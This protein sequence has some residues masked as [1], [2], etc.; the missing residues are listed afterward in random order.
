MLLNDD[1]VTI[2]CFVKL[3]FSLFSCSSVIATDSKSAGEWGRK[4]KDAALWFSGAGCRDFFIMHTS[5]KFYAPCQN[6]FSPRWFCFFHLPHSKG[7]Q[8]LERLNSVWPSLRSIGTILRVMESLDLLDL[9]DPFHILMG[10]QRESERGIGGFWNRVWRE[11]RICE[12]Q[13]SD[14]QRNTIVGL[15]WHCK[16]NGS[17]DDFD[18]P[19]KSCKSLN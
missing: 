14:I 13:L 19:S 10:R 4:G 8:W 9:V 11:R 3:F 5:S 6:T 18:L 1:G 17:W 16:H 15:A 7:K 12:M 2:H